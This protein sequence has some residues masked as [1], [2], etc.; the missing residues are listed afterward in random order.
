M[1]NSFSLFTFLQLNKISE[2][3]CLNTLLVFM[4]LCAAIVTSTH[5]QAESKKSYLR[6][7]QNKASFEDD[8]L[9]ATDLKLSSIGGLVFENDMGA[10][11][12]LTYL[13]SVNN[14]DAFT[15]DFGASY[16]YNWEVSLFIGAGISLGY[17]WDNEKLVS[18]YYPE[19]G[20][21]WDVTNRLGLTVSKK[22]IYNIYD[23]EEDI[24][25]LGIV[26]R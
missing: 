7:E 4:L 18:T 14:G 2:F 24:V 11:L 21:V 19:I 22:R 15:L 23:K 8:P 13:E 12:D 5:T 10:H 16:V 26:F 20:V 6:V 17:N 25:M 1:L 9:L 3:I